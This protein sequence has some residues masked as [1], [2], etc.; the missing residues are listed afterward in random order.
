MIVNNLV[1]VV[2]YTYVTEVSKERVHN[3]FIII[4]FTRSHQE[5]IIKVWGKSISGH[6]RGAI[7]RVQSNTGALLRCKLKCKYPLEVRTG[8]IRE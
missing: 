2:H 1:L 3:R 7:I 6:V 5:F 4:R 8:L